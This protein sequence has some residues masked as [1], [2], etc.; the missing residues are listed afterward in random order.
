MPIKPV[1]LSSD[2]V[3]QRDRLDSPLY[4]RRIT[5]L[6]DVGRSSAGW[7][8]YEVDAIHQIRVVVSREKWSKWEAVKRLGK[9]KV[10][11]AWGHK[12]LRIIYYEMLKEKTDYVERLQPGQ[13]G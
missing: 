13:A 5:Q 12:M 6:A 1:F 4:S 2:P 3:V 8:N 7:V 11:V 9:K 10:Q